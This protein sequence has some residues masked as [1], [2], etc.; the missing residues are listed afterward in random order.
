MDWWSL[1]VL[2]FEMLTGSPP[3]QA[4][5]NEKLKKL[6]LSQ[7]LKI[8]S[9]VSKEA[10]S[11]ISSMLVRDATKRL[12]YWADGSREVMQH[13]FFKR[14]DWGKLK[15]RQVRGVRARVHANLFSIRLT[16]L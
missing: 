9:Y 14:M 6:I 1:G 10:R 4:V 7:K 16:R 8:P 3:F 12:G 5:S 2:V 15:V 13:P 11:L